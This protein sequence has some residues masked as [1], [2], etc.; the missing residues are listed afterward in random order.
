MPRQMTLLQRRIM[1]QGLTND[2]G[3]FTWAIS[4]TAGRINIVGEGDSW[5][6]Y[7]KKHLLLGKPAN[8]LEWVARAIRGKG[9]ANLL[10]LACNGDEAVEM[11]AGKQKR[12]LAEVL[13]D[14][15]DSIHFILF[16]GGG[17][18]VVGKWDMERLL[19]AYQPGFSARACINAKRFKRKLLQIRL[20][21]EE[22]IELRNEYAPSACII[23]HTYDFLKPGNIPARFLAGRFAVG[24][25]I[26]PYL[27]EKGIPD[28][29]HETVVKHLLRDMRKLLEDLAAKPANKDKLIV[30]NTQGL[31]EPGNRRY[32]KDEM[33]PTST[34]FKKISGKIYDQ[35]RRLQPNLPAFPR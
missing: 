1:D 15:K 27:V 14:S 10:H 17:N 30:V 2:P 8:I 31:L 7:P 25:W 21:Y 16:S 33:H 26:Y 29:L 3:V 11:L 18:D 20:A 24:P 32:W 5:F 28:T 9:K 19:N 12:D 35:M 22:L 13:K 6:A 4:R 23:T 34:G